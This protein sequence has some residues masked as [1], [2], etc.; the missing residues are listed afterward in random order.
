M[1]QKTPKTDDMP[2]IEEFKAIIIA[3]FS[4]GYLLA[5][6]CVIYHLTQN[7]LP[8]MGSDLDTDS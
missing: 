2:L 8:C 6:N 3:G 4:L 1:T 5:I 7:D